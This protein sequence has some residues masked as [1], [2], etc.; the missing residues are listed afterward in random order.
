MLANQPA[1][2]VFVLVAMPMDGIHGSD[3]RAAMIS[4]VRHQHRWAVGVLIYEMRCGRSPF[5][6]RDQ[7][8]M[9]KKI[10]R[11][12]FTFPRVFLTWARFQPIVSCFS[13][14]CRPMRAE[15]DAFLSV[16]RMPIGAR[17]PML[18][19]IHVF[20]TSLWTNRR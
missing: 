4:R 20:R 16:C 3:V 6:A 7:L 12:D 2:S 10:S 14:T 17:N 13:A 19:P 18:C 11:R 15:Q 1:P 8:T 5:E 9:F